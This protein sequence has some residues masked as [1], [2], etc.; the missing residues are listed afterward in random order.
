M[1]SQNFNLKPTMDDHQKHPPSPQFS[2]S[3]NGSY[4]DMEL[5]DISPPSSPESGIPEPLGSK[6]NAIAEKLMAQKTAADLDTFASSPESPI[7]EQAGPSNFSPV[8]DPPLRSSIYHHP[9]PPAAYVAPLS[10]YQSSYN[11][12]PYSIQH[13]SAPLS[14][15]STRGQ[16]FM[17]QRHLRAPGPYRLWKPPVSHKPQNRGRPAKQDSQD[18]VSF[19]ACIDFIKNY[20]LISIDMYFYN[21]YL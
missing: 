17:P 8:T 3:T 19:F 2:V 15:E 13:H 21:V 6:V 14:T 4:N 16:Y 11:Y 18:D 5:E 20:N 10:Y 7:K 1:I 12:Y 9:Q